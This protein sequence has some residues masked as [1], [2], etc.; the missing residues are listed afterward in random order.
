[1]NVQMEA[2]VLFPQWERKSYQQ[3]RIY[4]SIDNNYF[5]SLSVTCNLE[6]CKI[7]HIK[8]DNLEGYPLGSRQCRVQKSTH[9]P[10]QSPKEMLRAVPPAPSV[11]DD[12]TSP[13]YTRV[14]TSHFPTDV[15]HHCGSEVWEPSRHF[16]HPPSTHKAFI[17]LFSGWL[18]LRNVNNKEKTAHMFSAFRRPS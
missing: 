18:P 11:K 10:L 8:S 9:F 2:N 5:A 1:M 14:S 3:N 15:S 16:P 4:L 13:G 12:P 6:C 17:Y 7:L